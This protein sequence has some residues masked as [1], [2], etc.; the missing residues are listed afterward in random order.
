MSVPD[1]LDAKM[2]FMV[3]R[4][5]QEDAD[6][7]EFRTL[8]VITN[9]KNEIKSILCYNHTRKKPLYANKFNLHCAK[10]KV[11]TSLLMFWANQIC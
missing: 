8:F 9:Y 7:S 1:L 5:L 2:V 4:W 10:A 3:T 6:V 11:N